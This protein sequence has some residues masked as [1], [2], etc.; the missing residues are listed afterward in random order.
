MNERKAVVKATAERY[1]R[2]GKREKGK[3]LDEFTELTGYN[4]S[5]ARFVLRNTGRKVYA[6]KKKFIAGK[7]AIERRG[8]AKIYGE[9][10]LRALTHIWKIYDYLCGKR[11]A[12]VMAE[13]VEVLE[14]FGEIRL[15][16]STREKLGRISA[17][18]IDRMLARER[19]RYELKGRGHTR[20]GTLLKKQI[21]VRTFS[22]WDDARPGF[23]EIDLVAHEGG[24]SSGEFL[25]TLVATDIATG[26]TEVKG[27]RNKAQVWVF[28]AL[29]RIR[30][31]LP[32]DLLGID[33]DNG[34]EFI[35]DHL[36]R[37][38]LAEE[39]TFTRSRPH[40]KNDNC[41]VEQKNYS[42]VR[43]HIGYQRL[44]SDGDL[45][46]LNELYRPLRLFVNF[47]QPVMKL[48]GK[49]RYGSKV[50]KKHDRAKTPYRRMLESP[51]VPEDRKQQLSE[52]YETLNPAALM[53]TIEQLRNKL[54]KTAA[55]N[56]T[57]TR[58]RSQTPWEQT[59]KKLFNKDRRVDLL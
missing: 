21:P 32:V 14:K 48:I 7:P 53:R 12:P 19:G 9:E 2:S 8:R 46:T 17:A 42:V 25:F 26:W 35:N 57:E 27:V 59:N 36:Y 49:E 58:R 55:V 28:E 43:R 13:A 10:E 33:S 34:S 3:I 5:Y 38:C 22:E 23:T 11:L 15:G 31:A 6:R 41:F 20:P 56:R 39:I 24:N 52:L 1:Q 54:L 37:Y 50:T 40:R 16:A 47:F 44:E 29:Q 18:T 45:A 51:D 4:R 30:A